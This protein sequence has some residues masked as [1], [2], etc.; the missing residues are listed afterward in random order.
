MPERVDLLTQG[1]PDK[2]RSWYLS[3]SQRGNSTLFILTLCMS[4]D[5]IR[6]GPHLSML[7]E[8]YVIGLTDGEGSFTVF[9]RKIGKYRKI[10]CHFY[11]K[12]R[13]EEKELLER[14]KKFF[15]CGRVSFQKDKRRNHS[16]CYRYE[17]GNIKELRQKIIPVFK[18]RLLSKKRKKDFEIFCK[19]LKLVESKA[20]LSEE[21]W[22][23][24][25]KL[26]GKM[27]R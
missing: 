21:G 27:H 23:R 9:Q 17:V 3:G 14:L 18:G 4:K 15:G 8:D 20:H 16:D 6:E 19:I 1:D 11:V 22:E 25:K 26:K 10:E 7:T 24:I 13:K 5:K 2:E 12:M